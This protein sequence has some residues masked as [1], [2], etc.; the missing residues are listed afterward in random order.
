VW[1]YLEWTPLRFPTF[2]GIFRVCS[3][4]STGERCAGT[5]K[6]NW[7]SHCDNL[8]LATGRI[9]YILGHVIRIVFRFSVSTVSRSK[10]LCTKQESTNFKLP[11]S[12]SS[13][14][15]PSSKQASGRSDNNRKYGHKSRK[16]RGS[17]IVDAQEKSPILD[18]STSYHAGSSRLVSPRYN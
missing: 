6:L 3:A 16:R 4:L 2:F 9:Y 8:F 7:Q 1:H 10:S 12:H 11:R 17:G 13:P 15:P 14:S 5:F 18:W